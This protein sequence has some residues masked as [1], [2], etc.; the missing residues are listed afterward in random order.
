MALIVSGMHLAPEFG[1][2]VMEIEADGFP[3]AAKV[4]MYV[5]SDRPGSI[6]RAMGSGGIGFAGAYEHLTPDI[7]IVLG[8]RFEM[9]AAAVAAVPF[10]I[11]IAHIAGGAITNGAID[12]SFRHSI[13]KLSSLHFVENALYARRVIQMGEEPW[14]VHVT[15]ALGLDNLGEFKPLSV[16]DL[17]G[18]FGLALDPENPP[19]LVTFHP[20]TREYGNT[21]QY[22]TEL[23]A[24]LETCGMP[25]VFTYPNADTGG[26]LIIEMIETFVRDHPQARAVPH[27]GTRAYFTLMAH[28]RAMVGN[29]SSGIIE[30]ASF[31]L[32]VVNIGT[33]QKGRLAPS[34]VFHVG[35]S[36][37][38]ILGGIQQTTRLEFREL[39]RSLFNPYGDGRAAERMVEVLRTIDLRDVRLIQKE[40]Y[41]LS[42][43]DT[44]IAASMNSA[45]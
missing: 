26:R 6:A 18:R 9:H 28:A 4:D 30:A 33:R 2:T 45:S 38:E 13:T 20:V 36:R 15:G 40:Y 42:A 8:D 29:S 32:P 3:I 37:N 39:L 16:D 17:N 10:L 12:D 23:L 21:H 44:G 41:D 31:R 25:L 19:L 43:D 22:V 35:Y 11:P 5:S 14:R 7:L 27:L 24:A 1:S 34:N